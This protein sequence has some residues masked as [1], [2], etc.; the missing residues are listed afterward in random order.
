[1][2]VYIC[3][4]IQDDV[5]HV[6]ETTCRT[7]ESTAISRRQFIARYACC[8]EALGTTALVISLAAMVIARSAL[9]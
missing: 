5:S 8:S 3:A 2:I 4:D 9:L 6:G 7:P 1:V